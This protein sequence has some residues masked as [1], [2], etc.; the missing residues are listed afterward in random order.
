MVESGP[1]A[2]IIESKDREFYQPTTGMMAS[3]VGGAGFHLANKQSRRDSRQFQLDP[4]GLYVAP[5]APSVPSDM[6]SNR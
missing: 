5:S 2:S 1:S 6:H 3:G 4:T